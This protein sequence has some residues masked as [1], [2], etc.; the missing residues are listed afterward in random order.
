LEIGREYSHGG[1]GGLGFDNGLLGG[2]L[3]QGDLLGDHDAPL[4]LGLGSDSALADLGGSSVRAAW[5]PFLQEDNLRKLNAAI[6]RR[7]AA[8]SDAESQG[9]NSGVMSFSLESVLPG[10]EGGA[11]MDAEGRRRKAANEERKNKQLAEFLLGH[12][13][14][15]HIF[16]PRA[17]G[18]N[19][20]AKAQALARLRWMQSQSIEE[21][22]RLDNTADILNPRQKPKK[23][24]EMAMAPLL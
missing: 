2:G 21:D 9:S 10:D 23:K 3:D 22:L 18:S 11:G 16:N 8:D 1:L 12:E 7:G 19:S 14:D 4:G 20:R 15:V 6:F 24:E 17:N 5:R 13:D